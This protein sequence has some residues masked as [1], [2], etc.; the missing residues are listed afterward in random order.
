M[1]PMGRGKPADEQEFGGTFS[2]VTFY[3]ERGEEFGTKEEAQQH[4]R[5]LKWLH[6]FPVRTR[7]QKRPN[8]TYWV[9][10]AS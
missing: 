5:N 1:I 8:G 9:W 10:V 4:A 6:T 7:V 3:H 2:K